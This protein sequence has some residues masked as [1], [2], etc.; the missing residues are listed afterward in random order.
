MKIYVCDDNEMDRLRLVRMV[1]NYAAKRSCPVTMGQFESADQLVEALRR[2]GKPDLLFLDIYLGRTDGMRLGSQLYEMFGSSLP[3]V[4]STSSEEH[5]IQAFR[6]H[7]AGYLHKPYDQQVFDHA[8]QRIEYLFTMCA[9]RIA[10]RLRE[11][12]CEK[13]I[14]LQDILYLESDDRSTLFHLW[15]ETAISEPFVRMSDKR[16]SCSAVAARPL[17]EHRIILEHEPEFCPCGRSYLVNLRHVKEITEDGLL[18][19]SGECLAIPYR[20]RGEM[21]HRIKEWR[22]KDAALFV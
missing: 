9:R 5:A 3:I 19:S 12:D 22:M 21:A 20:I 11:W 14:P 1:E 10:V 17:R 13:N 6:V 15:G 4:F 2:R 8:M 18:L 16:G 7:A